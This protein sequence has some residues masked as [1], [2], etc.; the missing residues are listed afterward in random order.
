MSAWVQ[1]VSAAVAA[2][3]LS[4]VLLIG[5]AGA[6]LYLA[7][8]L[9]PESL[10]FDLTRFRLLEGEG[11]A[12][13]GVL[14]LDLAEGQRVMASSGRHVINAEDWPYLALDI[15]GLEAS[16]R[17]SFYW[18]LPGRGE[19]AGIRL[20]GLLP[21]APCVVDLR[22]DPRWRGPIMAQGFMAAGSGDPLEIHRPRLLAEGPTAAWAAAACEWLSFQPWSQRSGNFTLSSRLS[23]RGWLLP[24]LAAWAGL[25]LGLWFGLRS[26]ARG[27]LAAGWL[28]IPLV[29]WAVADLRWLAN[30]WMQLEDTASQ[31]AGLSIDQRVLAGSDAA[32][33]RFIEGL[34]QR[35]LPLE[36]TNIFILADAGQRYLKLRAQYHLLPHR[37]FAFNET[38]SQAY[39]R[40]GGYLLMLNK[41][42]DLKRDIVHGWLLRDREVVLK[43]ELLEKSPW[44]DFYRLPDPA[45][46]EDASAP[47]Q[48]QPAP[49]VQQTEH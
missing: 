12:D 10:D 28:L 43:T 47:Q 4:A 15:A 40:H 24:A 13:A 32:L 14:R 38:P 23:E 34:K 44:G 29:A 17:L 2:L 45:P 7:D 42:P 22:A 21:G 27:R 26:L 41:P 11:E 25:A 16:D 1:R 37:V 33:S 36:P 31:Y 35:H 5:A 30:G 8:G 48:P 20:G 6:Y 46:E 9:K 49:D 3:G 18:Q 19:L 39:A